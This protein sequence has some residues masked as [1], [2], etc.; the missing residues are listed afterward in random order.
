[1]GICS[2]LLPA[3]TVLII[4]NLD[5]Q[6]THSNIIENKFYLFFFNYIN[7]WERERERV[8]AIHLEHNEYKKGIIN[9]FNDLD[10]ALYSVLR[11]ELLK[12]KILDFSINYAKQ[13]SKTNI[14]LRIKLTE[15]KIEKKKWKIMESTIINIKCAIP[16]LIC[17]IV[18]GTNN[19]F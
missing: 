1:M 7:Y 9:I 2:L 12:V 5:V 8:F 10:K 16:L 15:D 13:L 17:S 11:W 18:R 4:G 3:S 6:Y 19:I 14:K